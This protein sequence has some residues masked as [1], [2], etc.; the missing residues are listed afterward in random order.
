MSPQ[1]LP[2]TSLRFF[3]AIA[4]VLQHMHLMKGGGSTAVEFFF[5]L[6]GFILTYGYSNTFANLN[7][8]DIERFFVLRVARLYPI[9]L[10]TAA[11]AAILWIGSEWPYGAAH[12]TASVLAMQSYAPIGEKVFALNGPSWSVADELFFYAAFPFIVFAIHRLRISRSSVA[13]IACWLAVSALRLAISVP[14]IGKTQAYSFGWWLLYISPYVRVLGFVQGVLLAKL[15]LWFELQKAESSPNKVLWTS[16]EIVSLLL[17]VVS[18]KIIAPLPTAIQDGG[19][20]APSMGLIIIVFAHQRG[21]LSKVLSAKPLLHLGEISFSIYMIHAVVL[22]WADRFMNHT[23][24]GYSPHVWQIMAQAGL[25]LIIIAFSD[26][27]YRYV[28]T[29]CRAWAKRI[30]GRRTI[31]HPSPRSRNVRPE[32]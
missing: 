31:E 1:L 14:F 23:F 6:S 27:L 16:L 18:N 17:L 24:Y 13:L 25:T 12:V 8:R 9:Y 7:G 5:I 19:V 26:M 20:F 32:S 30:V 3:A 2:L 15:F 11:L 21:A 10:L 22:D 4:V 29:P 28:E